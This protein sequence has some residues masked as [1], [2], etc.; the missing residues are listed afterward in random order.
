[1][2]CRAKP[3]VQR[4]GD[5]DDLHDAGVEQPLHPLPD[6]GL[7]QP[8]DLGQRRVGLAAVRC[9][10][11]MMRLLTS[12]TPGPREACPRTSRLSQFSVRAASVSVP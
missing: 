2:A 1:M 3:S 7:G 12:S 8:D 4:I 9:S 6:R 10:C 5:G 11:S